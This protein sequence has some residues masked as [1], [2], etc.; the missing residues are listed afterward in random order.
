MVHQ[1]NLFDDVPMANDDDDFF[2]KLLTPPR[3]RSVRSISSDPK[4]G[5]QIIQE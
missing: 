1:M 5:P 2:N 3:R 4:D